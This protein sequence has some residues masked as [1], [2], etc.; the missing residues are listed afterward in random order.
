MHTALGLLLKRVWLCSYKLL[1]MAFFSPP[2]PCVTGLEISEVKSRM[3][4][5]KINYKPNWTIFEMLAVLCLPEKCP[6]CAC[7]EVVED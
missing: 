7:C 6:L 2:S 4:L 5:K 3:W 1:K